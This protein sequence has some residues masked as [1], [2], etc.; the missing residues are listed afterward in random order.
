[1]GRNLRKVASH[2]DPPGI[3]NR[4]TVGT[5]HRREP[6]HVSP[7]SIKMGSVFAVNK[8]KKPPKLL[9]HVKSSPEKILPEHYRL[10][11]ASELSRESAPSTCNTVSKA[12]RDS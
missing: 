10:E 5:S 11:V 3:G 7:Y 4:L 2:M 6:R 8:T 12:C 9:W 1:M